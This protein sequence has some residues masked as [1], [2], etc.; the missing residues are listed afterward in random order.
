MANEYSLL[1]ACAFKRI[2]ELRLLPAIYIL[3]MTPQ[4]TE[5][6]KLICTCTAKDSAEELKAYLSTIT[7]IYLCDK[8]IGGD[9]G[10]KVLADALVSNTTVTTITI[11]VT[12]Y[13]YGKKK[14]VLKV[15]NR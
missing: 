14:S 11:I 5:L 12:G 7:N 4:N 10:V 6:R 2:I 8:E 1:D 15:P 13:F 9:G 3:F